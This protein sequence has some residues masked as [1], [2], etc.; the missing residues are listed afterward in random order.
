VRYRK[1]TP[2]DADLRLEAWVEKQSGRRLI[3]RARCL[4]A[5]EVTAEAEA[6]FVSV[7]HRPDDRDQES[8]G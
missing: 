4:V 6:L 8:R 3:A 7:T 1:A 2:V 5:G